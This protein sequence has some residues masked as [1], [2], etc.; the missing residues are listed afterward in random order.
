MYRSAVGS[1]KKS[2]PPE[3][4]TTVGPVSKVSSLVAL[5]SKPKK[6]A[7]RWS[8]TQATAT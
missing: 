2:R 8:R 3:A 5:H 4:M 6:A 1:T 7:R